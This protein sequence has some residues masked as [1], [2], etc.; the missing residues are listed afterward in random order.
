VLR[1][2]EKDDPGAVTAY[3]TYLK[4]APTGRYARDASS[5]LARLKK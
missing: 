3:E 5:Q 4:L 2:N 1:Q